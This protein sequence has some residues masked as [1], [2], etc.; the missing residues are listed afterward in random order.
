MS[1]LS[2]IT[3]TRASRGPVMTR[4]QS[5][6]AGIEMPSQAMSQSPLFGTPELAGALP[7][8]TQKEDVSLKQFEKCDFLK[9]RRG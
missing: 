1:L 2:G 6:C 4:R 5:G 7:S 8:A 9:V 3:G